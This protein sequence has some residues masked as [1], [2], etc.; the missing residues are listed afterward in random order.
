MLAKDGFTFL[1]LTVKH[2]ILDIFSES[3]ALLHFSLSEVVENEVVFEAG[4]YIVGI[5][6]LFFA[7]DESDML[8]N[9]FL[10]LNQLQSILCA[11]IGTYC[12]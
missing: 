11:H 8:F 5:R 10:R 9:S 4:N 7:M 2:M 3:K 1:N 6:S 12:S